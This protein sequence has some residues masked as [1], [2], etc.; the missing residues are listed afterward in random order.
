MNVGNALVSDVR[1]FPVSTLNSFI[2][3]SSLHGKCQLLDKGQLSRN[4][5][6]NTE[7]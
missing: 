6:V 1:C 3:H 5:D 2:R 4:L 7:I